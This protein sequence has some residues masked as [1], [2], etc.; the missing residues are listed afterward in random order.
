MQITIKSN[1]PD[2]QKQLDELSSSIAAKATASSL[3]KIVAQAKTAMSR[4]IRGE[5]NISAA[6][7]GDALTITRASAKNGAFSLQASLQSPRKRGRS[8]NMINFLE[9]FVST[10]QAKKRSKA[11]TLNQLHVQIKKAG[12]KKPLGAAFIGNKGRTIFVRTGKSR[13]PIKALQTID[14]AQMFNTKRINARVL[15]VIN[16]RF[17]IIF[18]REAKYYTDRFNAKGAA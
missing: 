12:G 10:G 14:V 9:K 4:E 17:P 13:L 1:F 11:G 3:N 2:I 16:D 18:E 8:L 5:F 7:V 6:K 15:Q